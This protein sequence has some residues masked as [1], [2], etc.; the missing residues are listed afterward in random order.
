MHVNRYLLHSGLH[1][2]VNDKWYCIAAT[3]YVVDY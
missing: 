2:E 3:V 1:R